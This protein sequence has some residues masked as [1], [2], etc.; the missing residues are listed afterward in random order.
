MLVLWREDSRG[1]AEVLK[2]FG[3]IGKEEGSIVH[4]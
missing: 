3:R 4:V 2:S 1:C